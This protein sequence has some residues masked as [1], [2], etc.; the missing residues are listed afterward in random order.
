M[1]NRMI[2][3]RNFLKRYRFR[4]FLTYRIYQRLTVDVRM[5]SEIFFPFLDL[6]MLSYIICA[7][8]KAA[9]IHC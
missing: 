9:K 2:Q 6:R 3:E 7:D 1:K 4:A 8:R 5:L